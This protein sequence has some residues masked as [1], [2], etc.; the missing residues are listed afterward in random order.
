MR[1]PN[2]AVRIILTVSLS[3]AVV[4]NSAYAAVRSLTPL[5]QWNDFIRPSEPQMI[6]SSLTATNGW[7]LVRTIEANDALLTSTTNVWS[8]VKSKMVDISRFNTLSMACIAYGDG[9]G[10]GDPNGG[11]FTMRLRLGNLY[12][13]AQ[14]AAS[15]AWTVGELLADCNPAG[16]DPN[17][18]DAFTNTNEDHKWAEGAPT[19]TNYWSP[20]VVGSGTTNDVGMVNVDHLGAA[21]CYPEITSMTGITTLYVFA[22]GR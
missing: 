5:S 14:Y 2:Y 9:S 3:I 15:I 6:V 4:Q 21:G 7:F 22:W 19:V 18:P 20:A 17:G 11:S 8:T 13:P 10:G 16:T 12:G 1:S